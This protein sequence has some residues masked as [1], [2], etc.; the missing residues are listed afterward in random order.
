MQAREG[1]QAYIYALV[2]SH[3]EAEDILQVVSVVLWQKY[4]TF[5][6]GTNF[7]AWARSIARYK[8]LNERR[9]KRAF[10]W[11][12]DVMDA[13]DG[14]MEEESGWMEGMSQALALCLD[15]LSAVNRSIV[16]QR[17]GLDRSCEEIG[18]EVRRSPG[19]VKV[20]LHRIR[21]TLR[22]CIWTTLREDSPS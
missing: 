17:Y 19:S 9:R 22:D 3:A 10:C 4:D 8:V 15:K 1:L 11:P 21:S 2:G 16:Q 18:Q 13:I 5:I 6:P 20:I 7:G 12:P 14:A